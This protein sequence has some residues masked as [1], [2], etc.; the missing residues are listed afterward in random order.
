MKTATLE[1]G[2]GK[3]LTRDTERSGTS[4]HSLIR[5]RKAQEADP[6]NVWGDVTV[7]RDDLFGDDQ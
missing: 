3:D 7:G 1:V 4:R 5:S 2:F 6:I